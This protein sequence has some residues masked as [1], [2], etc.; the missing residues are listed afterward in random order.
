MPEKLSRLA[1]L[2]RGACACIPCFYATGSLKLTGLLVLPTNPACAPACGM[3]AVF[4]AVGLSSKG[5]LCF[6]ARLPL[7]VVGIEKLHEVKLNS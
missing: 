5:L 3:V 2:P 4:A 6:A 7:S 1:R